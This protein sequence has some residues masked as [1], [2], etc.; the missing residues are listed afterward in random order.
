[1]HV[2]GV[3]DQ[4]ADER[5]L[6]DITITR[7]AEDS[8]I[9]FANAGNEL[10]HGLGAHREATPTKCQDF[11]AVYNEKRVLLGRTLGPVSSRSS[12]TNSPA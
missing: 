10:L 1:M 6:V 12:P 3:R 8:E 9:R 4:V 7:L 2:G 11:F 5:S